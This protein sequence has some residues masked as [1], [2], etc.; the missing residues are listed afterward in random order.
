[1][2]M[3]RF[4]KLFVNRQKKG[5]RNIEAVRNR[6]IGLNIQDIH[7]VLEVGCGVGA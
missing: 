4:E 1:M 3:T 6:L 2:A 5:D 7:D